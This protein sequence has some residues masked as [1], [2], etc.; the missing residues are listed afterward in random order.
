MHTEAEAAGNQLIDQL[1]HSQGSEYRAA[2][3]AKKKL[4]Q[5]N[6]EAL[7]SAALNS[8]RLNFC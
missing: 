6:D 8:F 5:E 7:V 4:F 3:E 1:P 2:Y